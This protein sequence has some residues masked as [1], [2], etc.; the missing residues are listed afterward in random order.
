M[1]PL[2]RTNGMGE[3]E[4]LARVLVVEDDEA[5]AVLVAT[6]LRYEGFNVAVASGGRE[7]LRAVTDL[8]P[9]PTHFPRSGRPASPSSTHDRTVHAVHVCPYGEAR[10][11]EG[12]PMSGLHSGRPNA[13]A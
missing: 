5:I 7:A 4:Q 8:R 6:A 10:T 13:E 12:K 11:V 9:Q 2:G 3:D 1:T